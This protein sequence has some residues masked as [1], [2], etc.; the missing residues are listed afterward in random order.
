MPDQLGQ[1]SFMPIQTVA[2]PE[3]AGEKETLLSIPARTVIGWQGVRCML[4]PEW[5]VSGLSMD[6]DN[7]SLREI[8]R[9]H[10]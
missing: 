8:G 7:G 2:K 10:V 5:N 6:R 4:P 3:K 9:A 1:E